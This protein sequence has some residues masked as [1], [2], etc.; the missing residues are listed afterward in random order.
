MLNVTGWLR[1]SMLR[2][3]LAAA[4]LVAAVGALGFALVQQDAPPAP[5]E[6]IVALQGVD[7]GAEGGGAR[8]RQALQE[9]V[10]RDPRDGRA[11]ALLAYAEME[12]ERF[13]EAAAAFA[14]AVAV[15]RKVAADPGVWCD[16]AEAL[17]MTQEGS[18]IGRPT[19]LVERA[20]AMRSD[21]PKALEMAGSAAYERRDFAVAAI[22][23]RR[24][25]PKLAPASPPSKA[26]TAAIA[27]AERMASTSLPEGR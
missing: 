20:L 27:R 11:W 5:D 3:M 1:K 10:Q 13:E 15:S 8:S 14:Q 17:G 18:L 4:I 16:Y 6:K 22:Y 19:E 9:Q 25:L 12:A 26:L 21:Y 2:K 7:V 23:W 24:L